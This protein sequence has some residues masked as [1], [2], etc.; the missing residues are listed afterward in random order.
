[1]RAARS[2]PELQTIS[3]ADFCSGQHEVR[4]MPT[5]IP[6]ALVAAALLPLACSSG[7]QEGGGGGSNADGAGTTGAGG[8]GASG[9][10]GAVAPDGG[11]DAGGANGG[12]DGDDALIVPEGLV[13][14][15]EPGG[16]GVLDLFALTLRDGPDGL[17]LY[18]AL[19]NDGD[20]RLAMPPSRSSFTTRLGNRSVTGSMACTPTI[21]ISIRSRMGRP[22]SPLAR[23]PAT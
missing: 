7:A 22:R 9:K 4:F 17:E 21:S 20:V 12:P 19:R 5:K 8:G 11:N 6:L 14:T 2:P 1:V 13:V 16:A 10:D 18:A 15:L 3:R 23:A